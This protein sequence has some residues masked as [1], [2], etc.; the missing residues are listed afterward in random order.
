MSEVEQSAPEMEPST[1]LE[2]QEEQASV[3][4]QEQ[5]PEK[6]SQETQKL[7]KKLKL[8]VDGEEIEEEIDL[9]DEARLVKELQLA[10]A[11]KKSEITPWNVIGRALEPKNTE[12]Q[13]VVLAIVRINS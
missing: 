13:G 3:E 2:I 11:A 1:D 7:I 9:N 4:N 8:K 6:I 5:A 10:R 12:E